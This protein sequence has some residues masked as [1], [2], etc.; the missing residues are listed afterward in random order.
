MNRILKYKNKNAKALSVV[1]FLAFCFSF[2]A[3][4][5]L[6]SANASIYG[7][8]TC[9]CYNGQE[10]LGDIFDVPRGYNNCVNSCSQKGANAYSYDGGNITTIGSAQDKTNQ[11]TPAQTLKDALASPLVTSFKI[12]LIGILNLCG[13]LFAIAATLFSWVIDPANISGNSGM[14]NKQAVKDVWIMVRDLLNMTFILILLFAAFCT[15]FQVDKWNLKKVWLGIL[16]N[17]LLVNFSYPIARFFIDVSNVAFYYFVNNLFTSSTGAAVSGD[18]ILA[19]WGA[20]SKMGDILTPA[21][22]ANY[23]V[24]Y[25]IAM[26]V[27]VFIMGMTLLIIAALFI[28]R[29]VALT[30]LVMFSP[31]GFVGYIFPATSSFADKWW[32]QL[33][34]YS[35]FAPIMIFVMAI[36]IRV[37]EAM[38]RENFKS[39]MNHASAN[40]AQGK[41]ANW[42]SSAAFFAIPIIILWTGIGVAK[43]MGIE[44]AD[45]VVGAVKKGGK[46]LATRPGAV[47]KYGWKQS[48]VPGG[49]KKGWE[50]ARKSGKLF[51]VENPLTRFALKDGR[52]G[53]E[54]KTAGFMDDRM[55][56]VAKAVEKKKLEEFN[57]KVSETKDNYTGLHID[58]LRQN[59]K[60][61]ATEKDA[62][63][64][65]AQYRHF[66]SD[67][68]RREELKAAIAND[69]V[70]YGARLSAAGTG[71]AREKVIN[72]IMSE[73][74]GVFRQNNADSQSLYTTGKPA[75]GR[76]YTPPAQHAPVAPT[77]APA[78]TPARPPLNTNGGLGSFGGTP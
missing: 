32:K 52:E 51:G 64:Q 14:L 55:K 53:R 60:N 66:I 36:A 12:L 74:M 59:L 27:F 15:I 40:V 41:D 44:G 25:L 78:P 54:N 46:W 37:T 8:T 26:I 72:E 16:I 18:A 73:E 65:A 23:D 13:W 17:A 35:F 29:L 56:G 7:T 69:T 22:Y 39:F 68:S 71:R 24:A 5:G 45:K 42:I 77:P 61:P 58:E 4:F 34:S 57:K 76:R 62:A 67:S 9:Q 1:L 6:K 20:A 30:M 63:A 75:S 48:G 38:G 10:K 43:S 2:F 47:G 50:N 33:F 21:G 49:V 11:S 28:V 70:N 19:S 31:V 3:S